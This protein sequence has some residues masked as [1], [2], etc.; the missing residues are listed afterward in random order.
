M[1]EAMTRKWWVLLVRGV[2]G[3]LIGILAFSRP[4]LTVLSIVLAWAVFAEADGIAALVLALTGYHPPRSR[5][6]LTIA[7]LVGIAAGLITL[8]SPGIGV[9]VLLWIVAAWAIGRG[10]FQ[11]IAALELRRIIEGEWLMIVSGLLSI[12]FG[13][14]MIAQPIFGIH[15]LASLV[16]LYASAVGVLELALSFRVRRLGIVFA[17]HLSPRPSAV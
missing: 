8:A 12:V 5:W 10:V 14:V 15:T 2:F 13:C 11:I 9:V 4:G 17:R 16:G 3:V 7:G 6:A 1:F